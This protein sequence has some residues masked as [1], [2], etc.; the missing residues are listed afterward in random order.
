MKSALPGVNRRIIGTGYH[1]REAPSTPE[2]IEAERRYC[3][4][5]QRRIIEFELNPINFFR[6]RKRSLGLKV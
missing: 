1:H 3:D 6:L 4:E 5:L 2:E